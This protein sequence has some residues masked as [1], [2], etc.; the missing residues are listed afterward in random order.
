M[1]IREEWVGAYEHG[2]IAYDM[3]SDK[4]QELIEKVVRE[5]EERELAGEITKYVD[6]VKNDL[7]TKGYTEDDIRVIK[8]YRIAVNE[9]IVAGELVIRVCVSNCTWWKEK[10]FNI[11][12]DLVAINY[13]KERNDVGEQIRQ[14]FYKLENEKQIRELSNDIEIMKNKYEQLT[15]KYYKLKAIVSKLIDIDKMKKKIEED[16]LSVEE[17]EFLIKE[18]M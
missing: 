2:G 7:F 5:Y 8:R 16:G 3:F 14:E 4:T 9:Y 17:K 13:T 6:G 10:Y 18:L 1:L 12:L 11:Y 15:D